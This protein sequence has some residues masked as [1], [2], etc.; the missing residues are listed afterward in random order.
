MKTQKAK[1]SSQKETRHV[2][3]WKRKYGNVQIPTSEVLVKF[4]LLRAATASKAKE[5]NRKKIA[6]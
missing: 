2:E 5:A 4:V 1:R 6:K 3:N